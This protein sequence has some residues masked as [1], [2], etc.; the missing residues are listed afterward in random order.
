MARGGGLIFV[1]CPRAKNSSIRNFFCITEE[2]FCFLD[3]IFGISQKNVCKSKKN[4]II[5]D[6]N[7]FVV[8]K[9][10][11]ISMNYFFIHLIGV[12]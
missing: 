4:V 5:S 12:M 10:R 8:N 7:A 11:L 9:N 2:K 6:K 3:E 1:K